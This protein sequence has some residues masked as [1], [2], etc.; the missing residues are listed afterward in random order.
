MKKMRYVEILKLIANKEIDTNKLRIKDYNNTTWFW[1]DNNF[2]TSMRNND[3]EPPYLF[4]TDIYPIGELYRMSFDVDNLIY[5]KKQ[6]NKLT[7]EDLVYDFKDFDGSI[8]LITSDGSKWIYNAKNKSIVNYKNDNITDSY[9]ELQLS[10]L[11]FE[12]LWGDIK[13]P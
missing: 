12:I 11:D 5:I 13:S 8:N 7:I 4:L 10:Q 1:N 9:D 6:S 2:C 3:T